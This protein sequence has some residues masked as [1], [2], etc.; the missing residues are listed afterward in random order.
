MSQPARELAALS[1]FPKFGSKSLLKLK[2]AFADLEEVWTVGLQR[3][4][5]AG[6]GENVAQEFLEARKQIKVDEI[7]NKL[8][9]NKI[10]TLTV[11]DEDY[12]PLLREIYD[13]PALLFYKG[14][15]QKNSDSSPLAVVGSRKLSL[16]GK[17]V[18]EEIV[19]ELAGAGL[20]IVSG[21]AWGADSAAHA[22]ALK[23]GGRTV[24]VLGSGLD[25]AHIYPSANRRLAIQIIDHGG[26]MISEFPPGTL[27]LRHHFPIRN[28]LI[29]GL[30]LG[31][32]VVEAAEDS[33]S[34]ITAKLALEQNREVFGI[35]GNIFSPLSVGPNNLL[36]M[37]AQ[38]ITSAQDILD[39][40]SIK[41]ETTLLPLPKIKADNEE[42]ALILKT[43]SREPK[44]IDSITK[45][46]ALA[47]PAVL[48][49]LALMEMRGKVKNLGGMMYV[50][51]K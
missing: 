38:A 50:L 41:K 32:L 12:P 26:A 18:I 24:A 21:L 28:R 10:K 15:M 27:P 44:H 39:A 4:V 47:S 34:L 5:R 22:A 1:T 29:S 8:E 33:G 40:L 25:D 14:L 36:K 16:Y 11:D 6:I 20:S 42:E 45:E 9:K 46:A 37:G 51:A 13:P 31:T 2:R 48:S 17:Q 30:T 3:L 35:P 7:W 43:L 23:Q 19:S 49:S